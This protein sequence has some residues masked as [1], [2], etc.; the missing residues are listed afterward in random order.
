MAITDINELAINRQ[1][2]INENS[3]EFE[4]IS[5]KIMRKNKVTGKKEFLSFEESFSL[6]KNY[7]EH[8]K[9]YEYPNNINF[10]LKTKI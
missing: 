5:T 4:L 7:Q 3:G 9:I 6:L 8:K 2:I 10:F 1:N